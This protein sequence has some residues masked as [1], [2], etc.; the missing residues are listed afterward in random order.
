MMNDPYC[1]FELLSY[2]DFGAKFSVV[3]IQFQKKVLQDM[4]FQEDK[5]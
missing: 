2:A 1:D 3:T 4:H 5:H